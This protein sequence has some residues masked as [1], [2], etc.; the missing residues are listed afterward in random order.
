MISFRLLNVSRVK[1]AQCV[2]IPCSITGRVQGLCSHE[3][4]SIVVDGNVIEL[5]IP[6][7][8]KTEINGDAEYLASSPRP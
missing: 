2:L 5:G 6:N 7:L 4:T 1:G 3:D 8:S